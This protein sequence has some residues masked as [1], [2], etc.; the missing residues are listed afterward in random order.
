MDGVNMEATPT[1]NNI[2][3]RAGD[4]STLPEALNYAAQG[5]TGYNFYDGRGKLSAVL[6]YSKLL[7]EARSLAQRLSGLGLERG[8]R[9]ALVADT[10]PD[11]IRFFFACQYAGLIPV[12][13]PASIHMG[14]RKT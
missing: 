12:P 11:F 9:M 14:G 2:S 6:P 7:E 5:Q 10:H 8:A 1:L 4:F 13:L 3:L